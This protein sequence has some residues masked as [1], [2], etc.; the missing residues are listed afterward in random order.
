[1]LGFFSKKS[2]PPEQE[3]DKPAESKSW[4]QRLRAGLSRTRAQ[5]SSKLATVFKRGKIDDELYEELETIL[6]TSDVGIAATEQVLAN[7]KTRVKQDKLTESTEVKGALQ[8]VLTDLLR[9]LEK[10]LDFATHK[11][12]I[13]MV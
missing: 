5:L 10:P 11:P 1:M 8:S 3:Q 13:I 9:P 2:Q 12:F 6:L 7:L 4:A